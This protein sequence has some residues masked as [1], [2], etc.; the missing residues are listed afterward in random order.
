MSFYLSEDEDEEEDEFEIIIYWD[1]QPGVEP[2]WFVES[3]KNGE[4]YDDSQKCWFGLDVDEFKRTQ[5]YE[6]ESALLTIYPGA[7]VVYG[8]T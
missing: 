3:R 6:L 7:K 2:G 8:N 1:D 4:Y 5:K